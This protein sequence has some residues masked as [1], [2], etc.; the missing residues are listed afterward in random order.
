MTCSPSSSW[1]TW[2]M[3]DAFTLPCLSQL[4]CSETGFIFSPQSVFKLALA[5]HLA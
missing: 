4:L 5:Q 3:V 1:E 2:T